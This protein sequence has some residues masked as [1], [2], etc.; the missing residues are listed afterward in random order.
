MDI[1]ESSLDVDSD[2]SSVA[3]GLESSEDSRTTDCSNSKDI[4][5][6]DENRIDFRESSLEV[7][8]DRSSVALRLDFQR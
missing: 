4:E 7:D 3:L 6:T 1:R 8:S 2:R 5:S